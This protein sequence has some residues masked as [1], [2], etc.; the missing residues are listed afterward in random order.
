[1]PRRA[2]SASL[3]DFAGS[4]RL[5]PLALGLT[6]GEVAD[7]LGPP[8][9]WLNGKPVG[10]SAI[11][12]YGDAE[13]FFDDEDRVYLIQFDSFKVP[14]GGPTLQLLPW[15]IRH[16]LPLEELEQALRAAG[17]PFDT[18]PDQ[19]NPGCVKVVTS[20]GAYFLVQVEG[21][22]DEMGLCQFGRSAA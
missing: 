16:G 17:I 19:R 20:A 4:G 11:W 3:E 22:A 13:V 14:V 2:I 10:R 5:G 12:K 9:D 1:M 7:A 15:V 8:T 6:R 21:D 18:R